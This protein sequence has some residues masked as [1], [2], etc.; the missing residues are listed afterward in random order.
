[1]PQTAPLPETESGSRG[2]WEEAHMDV[3][4]VRAHG[5]VCGLCNIH[6]HSQH[7]EK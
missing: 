2:E 4:E 7:T 6:G 5:T 3:M 1:M